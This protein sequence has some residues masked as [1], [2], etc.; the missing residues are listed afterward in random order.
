MDEDQQKT[1]ELIIDMLRSC[2]E[3]SKLITETEDPDPEISKL[4]TEHFWDLI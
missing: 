1:S 3:L 2:P 4:I